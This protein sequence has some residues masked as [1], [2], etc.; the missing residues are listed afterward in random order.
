MRRPKTSLKQEL[1]LIIFLGVFWMAVWQ[2]FDIGTFLIGLFFA[3]VAVRLFFLPPLRG[4][5]RFNVFWGA[6]FGLRFLGKMVLAS[7]EV[8]WLTV[9]KGPRIKNSIISLQMRS[10]DDLV[11]TLVAHS[12]A[13]VPGSLVLEVDR[14]TATLYLH[15]LNVKDDETADK[16]RQDALRT[17][18][19]L[20]RTLGNRSDLAVV[21]AERRLR[22][23]AGLSRTERERS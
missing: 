16:I 14:P 22:R 3:T 20:I 5:G 1:P 19:L 7:F 8:S 10:H 11:I 18:A 6:V 2:S 17:E 23:V 15:A 4:S 13:L 21:K 12:L 9:V